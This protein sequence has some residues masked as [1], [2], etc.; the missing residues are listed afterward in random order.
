LK[1][2][3][4]LFQNIIKFISY[5][6]PKINKMMKNY[7]L[8]ILISLSVLASC[9]KDLNS[10]S[11][12]SPGDISGQANGAGLTEFVDKNASPNEIL[13][14]FKKGTSEKGRANALARM[15]GTQK[16]HI[17]TKAMARMG[18]EGVLY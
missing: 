5:P 11:S 7:V 18:D 17:L 8:I 4:K 2:Y 12:I 14:K 16:E 13:V 15:G 1:K 3:I 9:K 10:N 6:L